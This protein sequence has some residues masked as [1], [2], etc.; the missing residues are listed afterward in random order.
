MKHVWNKPPFIHI[1]INLLYR[2]PY[3]STTEHVL[4]SFLFSTPDLLFAVV[5]CII[6]VFCTSDFPYTE[7]NISFDL[8][9][10]INF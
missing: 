10:S 3:Q 9:Y 6:I 7:D 4:N 5:S 2:Y 1:E 8:S